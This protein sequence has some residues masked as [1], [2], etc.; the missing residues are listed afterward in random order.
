IDLNRPPAASNANLG[1]INPGGAP[2]TA[3]LVSD[4]D[5]DNLVVTITQGTKGVATYDPVTGKFTYTANASA[6]SGTDTFTYTVYDGCDTV[7]GTVTVN[8]RALGGGGGHTLGFWSNK[9]GEAK[10]ND[11]GSAAPELALLSGLNLRNGNGSNFDPT[12]YSSLKTWLLN[13][14]A[15]NMSYMLSVQ[16][17]AMELNVEAGFVN[18][19][20]RVYAADLLVL[21]PGGNAA[22]GL[23]PDGSISIGDLIVAANSELGLHGSA[24]S[25]NAWR[26][27]QTALKNA[28]DLAN[29]NLNFI[30]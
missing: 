4:A 19:S 2:T 9:N 7:A 3:T 22:I 26:V 29:N 14:T 17:A 10:I 23:A 27:Y 15:T 5:G 11:G 1:T 8:I 24:L 12:S 25:G 13:G 18:G 20:A 28:L 21:F 6:T 16:L 30:I